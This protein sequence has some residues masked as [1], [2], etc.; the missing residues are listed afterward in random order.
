MV[1]F[2]TTECKSSPSEIEGWR[3][4]R[5]R[6]ATGVGK[7]NTHTSHSVIHNSRLPR[8]FDLSCAQ[9]LD[10]SPA[11][12]K[13][14]GKLEWEKVSREHREDSDFLIHVPNSLVKASSS[15]Y[16]WLMSLLLSHFVWGSRWVVFLKENQTI[17]S[18]HSYIKKSAGV[19]K[20]NEDF[21]LRLLL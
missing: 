3:L 20:R 2:L 4:K 5:Q 13:L 18:S 11:G 9:I 6:D 14:P 1:A 8:H 10:L 21:R 19:A 17:F 16:R 7:Q 15:L 12:R